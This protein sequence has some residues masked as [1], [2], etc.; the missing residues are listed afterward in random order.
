[1]TSAKGSYHSVYGEIISDWKK[2][3]ETFE[4]SVEIPANTTASIYLPAAKNSVV[5]ENGKIIKAGYVEGKAIVKIGSGRYN[6]KV[7]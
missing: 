6:F 7:N 2:Y 3:G 4:L 1:M 5:R